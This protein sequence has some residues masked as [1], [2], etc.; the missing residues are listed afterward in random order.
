[1]FERFVLIEWFVLVLDCRH[2]CEMSNVNCQMQFVQIESRL[3]LSSTDNKHLG[4]PVLARSNIWRTVLLNFSQGDV[5]L[6]HFKYSTARATQFF[7][8][9]S[10]C[11]ILFQAQIDAWILFEAS[12]KCIA[13]LNLNRLHTNHQP[14]FRLPTSCIPTHC[15]PIYHLP[16]HRLTNAYLPT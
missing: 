15:L 10:N 9:N 8:S 6:V 4:P 16:T 11:G 12:F 13:H 5:I 2:P 14:T 7:K 1:M 3:I